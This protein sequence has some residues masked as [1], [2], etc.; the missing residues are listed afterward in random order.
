[1]NFGGVS[2]AAYPTVVW[3]RNYDA[4]SGDTL[5]AFFTT[6]KTGTNHEWSNVVNAGP[7]SQYPTFYTSTPL[8]PDDGGGSGGGQN[9]VVAMKVTTPA[10]G[11][12]NT[13]GSVVFVGGA[14]TAAGDSDTNYNYYNYYIQSVTPGVLGKT[15]LDRDSVTNNNG[16]TFTPTSSGV[17]FVDRSGTTR[18]V[19]PGEYKL[20]I[21][22]ERKD[23]TRPSGEITVTFGT[24]EA[25]PPPPTNI[26]FEPKIPAIIEGRIKVNTS[27]GGVPRNLVQTVRRRVP[28]SWREETYLRRKD[29]KTEVVDLGDIIVDKV[30]L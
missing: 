21:E 4:D 28:A 20:I 27:I 3:G 26:Q 25:P 5:A 11:S 13:S 15:H 19:P 22:G 10:N 6:Y 30:D 29:T 18:N 12:V 9:P 16:F 17:I 2:G 24:I 8:P 1:M 14:D 7:S 23:G